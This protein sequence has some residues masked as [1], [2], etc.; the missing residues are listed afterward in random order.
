MPTDESCWRYDGERFSPVEKVRPDH[1]GQPC[2][3]GQPTRPDLV[4]LIVSELLSQEQDFS[5]Y[6]NSG[7]DDDA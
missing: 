4:I 2:P 3:I 7:A 1:E 6:G 5:R